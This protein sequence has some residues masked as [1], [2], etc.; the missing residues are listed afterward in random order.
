MLQSRGWG[1]TTARKRNWCQRMH[2]ALIDESY[3]TYLAN[4]RRVWT[5]GTIVCELAH[6]VKTRSTIVCPKNEGSSMEEYAPD[7]HCSRIDS[8]YASGRCSTTMGHCSMLERAAFLFAPAPR[9]I[10]HRDVRSHR[11]GRECKM[12]LVS[13]TMP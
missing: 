13:I 9:S 11:G 10:G 2:H 12:R 6:P 3:S 1:K 8:A 5:E 7:H 4:L